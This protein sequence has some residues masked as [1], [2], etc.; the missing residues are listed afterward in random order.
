MLNI[1]EE[2]GESSRR[3]ILGSLRTGPKKVSELVYQTSLKQPNVSN[4][5]AR[6]KTKGVVVAAKVGREVYYRIATPELETIINSVLDSTSADPVPIDYEEL[7]LAYAKVAVRGDDGAC[8]EIIDQVLRSQASLLTI[9]QDLLG[10]AMHH[11]GVWYEVGAIDEAQEHM[12]SNITERMLSRAAQMSTPIKKQNKSVVLGCAAN[13]WHVLGIRMLSDFLKLNGWTTYYLGANTPIKS[14]F[15]TVL[16][17]RPNLVLL[18]C[19]TDV[20]EPATLE[21]LA[22]LNKART[23]KLNFL[24]GVGGS[25]VQLAP[26]PYTLAGADFYCLDLKEFAENYLPE[27][28]DS[29]TVQGASKSA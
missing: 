18:S 28:E 3:A 12:A 27:I 9:Y 24:I 21:L 20:G 16:D 6:L 11:V 10:P 14:F 13:N 15:N 7:A 26:K 19:S 4:H 8:A 23:K 17:R 1:Y 25:R 2:L 5:L 29:G 22:M